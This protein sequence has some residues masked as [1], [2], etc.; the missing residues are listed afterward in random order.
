M[1]VVIK[2]AL[3]GNH[4]TI[5]FDNGRW[6]VHETIY[7]TEFDTKENKHVL[8]A[9]KKIVVRFNVRKNKIYRTQESPYDNMENLWNEI[10]CHAAKR[11][12]G[13]AYATQVK[14]PRKMYPGVKN[15][16][17]P[18]WSAPIKETIDIA[19]KYMAIVHEYLEH[20]PDGYAA[21]KIPYV[22][23][24]KEGRVTNGIL[25]AF[26]TQQGPQWMMISNDDLKATMLVA[27][28][29]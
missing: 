24:A 17:E 20:N 4:C 25:D 28:M 11:Q 22:N 21:I 5:G 19:T 8:L 12:R 14:K 9:K 23:K 10:V 18:T 13:G 7:D 2:K 27:N 29:F 16:K 15:K 26:S 6:N 1:L 3:L